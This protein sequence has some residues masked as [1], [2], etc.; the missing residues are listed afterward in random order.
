MNWNP[1]PGGPPGYLPE[2]RINKVRAWQTS[3]DQAA[4]TMIKNA[5]PDDFMMTTDDYL[6]AIDTAYAHYCTLFNDVTSTREEQDQAFDAYHTLV[7]EFSG[8][9]F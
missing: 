3:I 5:F 8:I 7:N 4:E 1:F 6:A 2:D 9:P